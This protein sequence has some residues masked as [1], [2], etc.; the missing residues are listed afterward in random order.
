MKYARVLLSMFLKYYLKVQSS[1]RR[2]NGKTL[3]LMLVNLISYK[4]CTKP[5]QQ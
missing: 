2:L 1:N 5:Q 4:T 3:T